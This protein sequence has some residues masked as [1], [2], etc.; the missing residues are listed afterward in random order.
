M[1]MFRNIVLENIKRPKRFSLNKYRNIS[2]STQIR[3][4]SSGNSL[5]KIKLSAIKCTKFFFL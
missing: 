5:N 4:H 2:N 1:K 3:N